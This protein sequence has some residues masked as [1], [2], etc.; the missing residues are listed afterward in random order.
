MQQQLYNE[1]LLQELLN[2]LSGQ[3]PI[4]SIQ[5]LNAL[6]DKEKDAAFLC[7]ALAQRKPGKVY[8]YYARLAGLREQGRL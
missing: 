4:E 6:Y 7:R 1:E 5:L 3:D 2:C 8:L